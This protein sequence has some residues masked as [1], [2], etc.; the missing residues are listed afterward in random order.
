MAK[1]KTLLDYLEFN[2]KKPHI[3]NCFTIKGIEKNMPVV[4]GILGQVEVDDIKENFHW[5]TYDLDT[6]GLHH[7]TLRVYYENHRPDITGLHFD[8]TQQIS[9][10]NGVL[11]ISGVYQGEKYILELRLNL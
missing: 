4:Q 9:V 8:E 3:S 2:D 11:N 5:G 6:D 1:R 7:V 10:R